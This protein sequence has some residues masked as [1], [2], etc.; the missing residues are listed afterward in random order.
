MVSRLRGDKGAAPNRNWR[1]KDLPY[2]Q[3]HLAVFVHRKIA[4]Q[5]FLHAPVRAFVCSLRGARACPSD[6]E[7]FHN[8]R[9]SGVT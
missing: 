4:T 8:D 2:A 5:R 3:Y 6:T 1:I 7:V 9:E